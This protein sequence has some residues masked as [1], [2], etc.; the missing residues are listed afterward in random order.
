MSVRGYQRI[1]L[2]TCDCKCGAGKGNEEQIDR[3]AEDTDA[4]P[5]AYMSMLFDRPGH[6]NSGRWVHILLN[7]KG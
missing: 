3:G 6:R 5:A 7:G 1:I 2:S 4:D